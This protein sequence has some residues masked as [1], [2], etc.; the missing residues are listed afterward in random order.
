[1]APL[2]KDCT[3]QWLV[4][5]TYARCLSRLK[6]REDLVSVVGDHRQVGRCR[7]ARFGKR[8]GEQ[9]TANNQTGLARDLL[10]QSGVRDVLNKDAGHAAVA[11]LINQRRHI[12]GRGFAC[13]AQ[14]LRRHEL[15]P[16]VSTEV[17]EGVM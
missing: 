17:L 2:S 12:F 11:N 15:E 16:I 3:K 10:D 7:A 14:P 9:R 13:R 5:L 4:V 8:T 6:R 1:M